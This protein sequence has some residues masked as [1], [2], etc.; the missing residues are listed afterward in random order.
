MVRTSSNITPI[1][2]AEVSRNDSHPPSSPNRQ[3]PGGA[4]RRI[5]TAH[6]AGIPQSF[7]TQRQQAGAAGSRPRN[8]TALPGGD[9]AAHAS[10]GPDPRIAH[11]FAQAAPPLPIPSDVAMQQDILSTLGPLSDSESMAVMHAL[12][13]HSGLPEGT[14]PA[15]AKVH[16]EMLKKM[17]Q[18]M[19]R[20][21]DEMVKNLEKAKEKDID[22]E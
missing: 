8:R 6:F 7:S 4:V 11:F 20:I 12:Q 13:Q 22:K 3:D 9:S 14:H 5:S 19:H 16:A 15:V 18:Q 1:A 17:T 2:P 10:A 21:L